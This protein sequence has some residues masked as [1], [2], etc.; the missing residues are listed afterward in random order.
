MLSIWMRT[1]PTHILPCINV[2]LTFHFDFGLD[3]CVHWRYA[4]RRWSNCQRKKLKSGYVPHWGPGTKTNWPTDHRWQCNLK[5]NLRH[6][7]A[8]YRPIL[9]S[10]WAPYMKNKESNCQ[11]NKCNIWSPAPRGAR[12]QDELAEWPSVVMWLWL[13]LRH[14]YTHTLTH[15]RMRAH[16]YVLVVNVVSVS[17]PWNKE[18]RLNFVIT[19]LLDIS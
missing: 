14:T 12:H 6:C 5:L 10:E 8:N 1:V 7:T 3:H 4:P 9:S 19:L 11:L 18:L 16:T 15:T 17:F 2:T 13:W